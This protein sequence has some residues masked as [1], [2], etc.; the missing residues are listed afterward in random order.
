MNL[1]Q[2]IE[3]ATEK[4]P[5]IFLQILCFLYEQIPFGSKNI[6]VFKKNYNLTENEYEKISTSFRKSKK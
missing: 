1:T 4:N 3:I 5:E 6:E 2:F